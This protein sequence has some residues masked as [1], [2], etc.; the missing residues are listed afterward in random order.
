MTGRPDPPGIEASRALLG[1]GLVLVSVAALLGTAGG[2]AV[3]MAALGA[4]RSWVQPRDE[5]LP[6]AVRRRLARAGAV[7]AAGA[8]GWRPADGQ[9]F[10]PGA[11]G[12]SAGIDDG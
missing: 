12:R 9:R 3:T 8:Q 5:P 4:A 7:A 6:D 1:S 11:R 10:G 2:L